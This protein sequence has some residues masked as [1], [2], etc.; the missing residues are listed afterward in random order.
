MRIATWNVNSIRTRVDRVVDYLK[1]ADI[2]VLAMQEIKCKP[3]QFPMQPFIDAGY[4]VEL[5]GLNQWNGVAF[6]S[7][8]PATDVEIGFPE[9]P[10]FKDVFEARALGATFDGVRL[11]SLY[12]PNG[13]TLEDPHY[14]YKLEWLDRLA[15]VASEWVE[16]GEPI[17]LMGDFNIAPLA[18]DV[19]DIDD[20]I[21]ATHVSAAERQ[22]FEAFEQIGYIDSVRE[23]IP[24]GYTYWD[25]QQLRFPK[26][27]GMRI[28]FI[29][30]TDAFAE[31]VI[32]AEIVRDERKGEGPSDHVPV[33]VTLA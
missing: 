5:H 12:V 3:E 7:K 21:G 28:D 26:N 32:D 2:D 19:W 27:E 4:H 33:V 31:R 1:R 30:G 14:T 6:A 9:M 24:T 16:S 25:Y 18:T 8:M 13:R 23:R 17:A 11:W 15:A 29:L 10:S 22:A 20:F